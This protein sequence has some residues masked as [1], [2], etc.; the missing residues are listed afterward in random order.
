MAIRQIAV[1]NPAT[2]QTG[3]LPETALAQFP[4]WEPIDAP[5]QDPPTAEPAPEP[6]PAADGGSTTTPKKG[7]RRA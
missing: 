6:E 1:R 3:W 2:G 7:D 4:D 5:A